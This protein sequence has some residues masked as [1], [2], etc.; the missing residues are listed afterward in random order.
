MLYEVIK[1]Q[2]TES[3]ARIVTVGLVASASPLFIILPYLG[4]GNPI[5]GKFA[6]VLNPFEDA[7]ASILLRR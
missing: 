2:T 3:Q 6:K 7:G 5:I 4:I 1:T